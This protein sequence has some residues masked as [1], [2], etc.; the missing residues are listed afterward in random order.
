MFTR[1]KPLVASRSG[2]ALALLLLAA[3]SS[4]PALADAEDAPSPRPFVRAPLSFEPN[5]GQTR[6]D[7]QYS[8][9]ASGYAVQ[10]EG[11]GIR[12]VYSADPNQSLADHLKAQFLARWGALSG[13]VA[14]QTRTVAIEFA[15][16]RSSLRWQGTEE[17]AGHSNYFRG[18]DPAGWHRQIPHYARVGAQGVYPGIDV[19]FYDTAGKLEYDFD[20]AAGADPGRIRLRASGSAAPRLAGDGALEWSSDRGP[21][22]LEPP[23]AYQTVDGQR[24]LVSAVYTLR[25]REVGLRLGAYDRSVPLT[26]DPV[27]DFA[28]LVGGGGYATWPFG[29]RCERQHLYL[30][31]HLQRELSLD[32]RKRLHP[33]RR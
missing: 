29:D 26:I 7:I 12:L 27:L 3:I 13:G 33:G 21:M 1:R 20:V 6:A 15:H 23:V 14:A 8:A 24:H 32:A 31:L 25:G 28:A 22:R 10:F 11:S 9:Y 5:E 19:T 17:L 16:A 30:G 4:R 2:S 18:R